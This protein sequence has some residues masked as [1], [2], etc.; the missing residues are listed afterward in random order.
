MDFSPPSLAWNDFIKFAL[1]ILLGGILL[2][3]TTAL[4]LGNGTR[5]ATLFLL[6][7]ADLWQ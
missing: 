1:I 3:E 7:R 5:Y 6:S 4:L 2:A